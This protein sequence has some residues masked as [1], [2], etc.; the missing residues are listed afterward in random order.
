MN[1]PGNNQDSGNKQE[2][3]AGVGALFAHHFWLAIFTYVAYGLWLV[4]LTMFFFFIGIFQLFYA[5]PLYLRFKRR[6]RLEAAKGV[7]I[8]IG[9]TVLLNATCFGSLGWLMSN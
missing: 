7:L 6:G 3:L 9:I 8:G 5:I 4:P 2:L 1:R